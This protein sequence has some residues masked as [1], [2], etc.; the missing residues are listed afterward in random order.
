MFG[1]ACWGLGVEPFLCYSANSNNSI[2]DM[3]GK[4]ETNKEEASEFSFKG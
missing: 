4:T 2:F 1:L 3:L